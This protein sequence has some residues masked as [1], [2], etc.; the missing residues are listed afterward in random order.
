MLEKL[1]GIYERFKS[2]EKQMNDPAAMSDMKNYIKL[3]KDYKD[4]EPIVEAY[5]KYKNILGNI[6]S[7]KEI[8]K[9]FC[10]SGIPARSLKT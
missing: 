4:L 8:L 2:I 5:H 1:E 6:E 9:F 10:P 3:N 7:S